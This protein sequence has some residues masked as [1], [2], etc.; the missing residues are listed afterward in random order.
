MPNSYASLNELKAALPDAIPLTETSYDDFLTDLLTRAS[1]L[2][3]TET[4]RRAGAYAM[5]SATSDEETR[6]FRGSGSSELWT[7][8][9]ATAPSAV[10]VS[11]SGGVASS[12]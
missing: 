10:G 2:I 7:G 5:P 3:D 8:E 9:M 12:D 1:R 11:L 6:Y 4:K